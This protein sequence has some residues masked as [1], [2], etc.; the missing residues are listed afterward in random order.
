MR[1]VVSAL[2]LS[3]LTLSVY[4]DEEEIETGSLVVVVT[5]DDGEALAHAEVLVWS[6]EGHRSEATDEAG[7][8]TL[9]HLP[10]GAYAAYASARG[11]TAAER[12]G[13]H[14]D[15]G[16]ETRIEMELEVGIPFAGL[17]V[18]PEDEPIQS[19]YVEVRRGGTFE[20]YAEVFADT[21]PY[22]RTY[23]DEEGRFFIGGIPPER[24]G[25]V[26][27]QAEDYEEA[28]VC[29]RAVGDVVRPHPLLIRLVKGGEI[30]GTVVDPEGKPFA[31]AIVYV[32]PADHEQLR[33]NPRIRGWSTD[34]SSF[35]AWTARTDEEGRYRV[36]GL[37]LGEA[38]VALADTARHAR[39]TWS[40]PFGPTAEKG[41]AEFDLA[42]RKPGVLRVTLR[43]P[44]GLDLPWF[45]AELGGHMSGIDA[46]EG[47]EKNV[48][49]FRGLWPGTH[50]LSITARGFLDQ[51]QTVEVTEGRTVEVEILLDPGV[52]IEGVVH[53]ENGRGVEGVRVEAERK[54][55][56]EEGWHD[57]TASRADTDA[58]GRFRMA[59]LRP[60]RHELK[61]SKAGFDLLEPVVL[62]APASDVVLKGTNLGEMSIRFVTPDGEIVSYSDLV[63]RWKPD[64]GGGGSSESA[65]DGVFH[66]I[67]FRGK[68]R[69]TFDF[70]GYVRVER[71]VDIQ[72]GEHADFGTVTL[73]V[74]LT[75]EGKVV[76]LAGIP[77][78]GA[79]VDH[80]GYTEATTNGD[81]GFSLRHLPAGEIE[82]TLDAEGF[83][84]TEATAPV[85]ASAKPVVLA[86]PRGVW[87][88]GVVRD[89]AGEP[90][91]EHWFRVERQNEAGEWREDDYFS[92]EEDG[93]FELRVKTGPCRI[94][95][96]KER[97]KPAVVL[98][99]IDGQEGE[100]KRLELVLP[101]AADD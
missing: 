42:L 7:S 88:A 60:G 100:T 46:E 29:V 66:F 37:P 16:L 67:G 61:I 77:V 10:P 44:E 64:G 70:D 43:A 17:V 25:T 92:T 81:G 5:T 51:R 40:A 96:Y 32:V 47:T 84:E 99:E 90:L 73:D 26:V 72:P 39:S 35:A 33:R 21:T 89:E 36:A 1:F 20:G 52:A 98:S 85:S 91:D 27:V 86:L 24:V 6:A 93:T 8:V 28:R 87:L 53:D 23:T 45:R 11:R 4:A 76:D 65:K 97:G 80:A 50:E 74:G 30:F 68:E 22:A 19:T 101:L 57:T 95:F 79:V 9:G 38:Y 56:D 31:N 59:G 3:L 49:L 18:G 83:L 34:G 75:L 48:A 69:F 13:V 14:V 94:A 55:N 12:H 15:E 71:S 58:D 78:A 41:A 63:W 62:E 54:A 2:L 82:L